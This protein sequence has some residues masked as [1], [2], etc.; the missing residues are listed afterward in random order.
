M[1]CMGGMKFHGVNKANKHALAKKYLE[2]NDI[3]QHIYA[4]T[5]YLMLSHEVPP[6]IHYFKC[7]SLTFIM[8]IT[9]NNLKRYYC[10]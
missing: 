7:S 2:R 6:N 10:Y 3:A 5:I 8:K 4:Y 9:L 1:G